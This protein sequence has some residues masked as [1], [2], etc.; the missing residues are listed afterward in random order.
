MISTSIALGS[1][2]LGGDG[3]PLLMPEIG[4]Y[5]NR[6]IGRACETIASLKQQGMR[7]VKAEV[8]LSADIVSDPAFRYAYQAPSGPREESY[9]AI[10]ERKV[11]P[12]DDWTTLFKTCRDL[13]LPLVVSVYDMASLDFAGAEGAAGLKLASNN[14]THIPLL[15]RAAQSGAAVFL[16]TGKANL[17]DVAL[18]LETVH[19]CGCERVVVNHNPDGHPAP[20]ETH[21]LRIIETYR[22][23]FGCPVGLSDHYV[24]TEMA[25]LSVGLG[26]AVIE[27]PVT[28]D[29]S[30]DEVDMPW[31]IH[32]NAAAGLARSLEQAWLALG[33]PRRS[34][35]FSDSDH[36]ARMGLVADRPIGTGETLRLD[37]VRFAWPLS[38][39]AARDWDTVAG[40]RVR[41]NIP[42]GRPLGWSD[43]EPD[44]AS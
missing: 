15:R 33:A 41:R 12:R 7:I 44:A 36:P 38:G 11:M 23:A 20:A 37:M 39:I 8:F 26:Y 43:V 2:V 4:S 3:P 30:L 27:K 35:R 24:G 5:F 10:V 13:G 6:D 9:R 17:S 22:S 42:E 40:W 1:V 32:L 28:H 31:A 21:N 16:D 19:D 18:A 29:L 14:L 25:V 34:R